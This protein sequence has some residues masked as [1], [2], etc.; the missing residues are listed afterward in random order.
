MRSLFSVRSFLLASATLF[1]LSA[2]G[3][4]GDK[5]DTPLPGKREPVLLAPAADM[6]QLEKNQTA[7]A[8]TFPAVM[9]NS[10]WAQPLAYPTHN[11]VHLQL[12]GGLKTKLWEKSI[13]EGVDKGRPLI[14]SPVIANNIVYA[15]DTRGRVT[16]MDRTS[17]KE[18]WREESRAKKQDK[19][20]LTAGGGLAYG[21]G[22]LLVTNGSRDLIALNAQTGETLWRTTLDAPLRG[23]PTVAAGRVYVVDAVNHISSLDSLTGTT[24]WHFDGEPQDIALLGTPA[25]AVDET[26]A[27]AA[28]SNG[29]IFSLG[30]AD[31][32]SRWKS[33]FT[34]RAGGTD[35]LTDLRDVA[36]VPVMDG[37]RLMAVNAS[38][39]MIALDV[40]TGLRIWQK[41]LGGTG[42][43]WPA[44]NVVYVMTRDGIMARGISDGSPIWHAP[45]IQYEDKDKEKPIVWY[46]PYLLSGKL[47]AFGSA[48]KA[49]ILD[50][51]TGKQMDIVKIPDRLATAPAV[52]DNTLL[53]ITASGRLSAWQ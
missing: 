28:L 36:G 12:D 40:Q 23:A 47:Y 19:D 39:N 15:L 43:L 26:Q 41:D 6:M 42:P 11:P 44:G 51:N 29:N 33:R 24:T 9:P 7:T 2:C 38:G 48:G 20:E 5:E 32:Q 35:S 31:G 27:I 3:W 37:G 8:I 21:R 25:P 13:G 17:G 4:M 16:A 49:V 14:A 18:I 22:Q 30:V 45:L 1:T 34:L 10:V 53:M 46:G 50:P 52:A